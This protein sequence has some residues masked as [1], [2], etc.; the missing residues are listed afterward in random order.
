[1]AESGIPAT[2]EPIQTETLN[3]SGSFEPE[4]EV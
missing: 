1:M 2:L 3:P 4:N